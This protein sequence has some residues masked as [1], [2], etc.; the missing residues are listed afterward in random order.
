MLI[1]CGRI[2]IL[3]EESVSHAFAGARVL[4]VHYYREQY[5]EFQTTKG[6][7]SI[8]YSRVVYIKE[9]LAK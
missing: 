1:T 6:R 2:T 9:E 8:P 7:I 5:V 3:L 4:D